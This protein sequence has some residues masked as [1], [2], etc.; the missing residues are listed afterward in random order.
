MNP[1]QELAQL[2]L[3]DEIYHSDGHG[4]IQVE[5]RAVLT[6]DLKSPT[7]LLETI[8]QMSQWLA[9]FAM[10]KTK[11]EQWLLDLLRYF[12]DNKPYSTLCFVEFLKVFTARNS[13]IFL[14]QD[15]PIWYWNTQN[16]VLISG[17]IDMVVELI[18]D[19]SQSTIE[20]KIDLNLLTGVLKKLKEKQ[21]QFVSY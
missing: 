15:S 18:D 10:T 4:H 19:S 12:P 14:I 6:D 5:T 16:I 17:V 7:D 1:I 2:D 3:R 20:G 13:L 9:F 8:E 11:P 21:L